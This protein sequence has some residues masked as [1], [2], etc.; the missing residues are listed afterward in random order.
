VPV[1]RDGDAVERS[2]RRP[3]ALDGERHRSGRLARS[4]DEGAAARRRR[5]V[6]RKDLERVGR[7]DRGAEA[8][9]EELPQ[10]KV[11]LAASAPSA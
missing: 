10:P 8:L 6:R 4:R 9:F 5:Q 2:S 11:S 1:A 7:G 3:V